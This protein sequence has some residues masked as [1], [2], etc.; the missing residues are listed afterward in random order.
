VLWSAGAGEGITMVRTLLTAAA[1]AVLGAPVAHSA[2]GTPPTTRARA[3]RTPCIWFD[4]NTMQA[5]VH[6][7]HVWQPANGVTPKEGGLYLRRTLHL[8]ISDRPP[9]DAGACSD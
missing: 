6:R 7:R 1:I 4:S 2:A 3:A 8:W 5:N 9:A